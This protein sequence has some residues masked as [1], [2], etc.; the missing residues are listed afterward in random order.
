[1][2][3]QVIPMSLLHTSPSALLL[4]LLSSMGLVSS[5]CLGFALISAMCENVSQ[6]MRGDSDTSKDAK[7]DLTTATTTYKTW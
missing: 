4:L 3:T 1:M 2:W 5:F 6:T 7:T